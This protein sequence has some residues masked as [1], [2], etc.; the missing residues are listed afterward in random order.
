MTTILFVDDEV[1]LLHLTAKRLRFAGYKVRLAERGADFFQHLTEQIPSLILLDIKLPDSSGIELF[2][3][4]R[5][6]KETA[7]IP[8]IFLSALHEHEEYCMKTLKAD[9][10]VKKPFEAK[11]LLHLLKRVLEIQKVSHQ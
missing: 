9:G 2:Q 10:F 3:K 5:E 4:L 6:K 8:V 1:D 7:H 11:E